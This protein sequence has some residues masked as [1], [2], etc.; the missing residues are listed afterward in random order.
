MRRLLFALKWPLRQILLR[1]LRDAHRRI[2][3]LE[4]RTLDL[5]RYALE[6]IAEYLQYAQI[7][8]D[9]CEFGVAQGHSFVSAFNLMARQSPDMHFHHF[10]SFEGL[11]SLQGQ[12]ARDAYTSAFHEG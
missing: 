6:E 4:L 9:Y 3:K 1:V 12:D 2:D 10:D 8:G 5:R 11:P 7:S